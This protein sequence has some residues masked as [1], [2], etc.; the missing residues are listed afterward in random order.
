MDKQTKK[1]RQALFNRLGS[2]TKNIR[3][4]DLTKAAE[5]FG[6]KLARVKGDHHIFT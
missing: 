3:F 6:F 4:R 1:N 2:S 5:V